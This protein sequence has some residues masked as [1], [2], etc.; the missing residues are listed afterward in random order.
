ML[1]SMPFATENDAT[2]LPCSPTSLYNSNIAAQTI[3]SLDLAEQTTVEE[4]PAG[5]N[6]K[7]VGLGG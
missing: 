7:V 5:S 1:D 6:L 4:V 2:Q 3:L